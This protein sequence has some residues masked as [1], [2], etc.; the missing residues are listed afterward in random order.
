MTVH[1]AGTRT[2]PTTEAAL[3][4]Q[5]AI[6]RA[7]VALQTRVTRLRT[8]SRLLFLVL[9]FCVSAWTQLGIPAPAPAA[10][11]PEAPQDALG[12]STPRGA[13]LG[14]LGASHKGDNELAAEYLNTRLRGKAATDLAHQFFVVLDRRLPAQLNQLSDKPEGSLSDQLK[15]DQELVGTII[16]NDRKLDIFIERV[17]RGKSGSLWLFSSKTLD[18]IPDLYEEINAL[19]VDNVLPEFLVNTRFA[20]IRLFQWVAVFV[21]MPLFY[22]LTTLLNRVLSRLIG[23]F[24]RRLYKKPGLS[25][26]EVLPRP[27]RILLLAAVIRWLLTQLSLPLLARQF[28]SGVAVV[29]TIAGCVW[30]MILLNSWGEEYIRKRLQGSNLTGA[31]SILRLARWAIDGLIV[32]AGMLVT[33][34]YFG[35]KPT[36]ALAGLGVGGIAVALAAQKTLENVIGG[37]SLILDRAVRVG[38]TLKMGETVGTIDAIGLRSTRIRTL[39]RTVVSVPNGQISNLSLENLSARDKFW[40]HPILNL[41]VGTTSSKMHAV[42]ESIRSLLQESRHVE[43]DS[44]RVRFLRFGPSS[45]D[46]EVFAYV[47]ASDW[48]QFLEIQ[49]TLLLRIMECIESAG[50][51]VALP[52]QIIFMSAASA[53]PEAGVEGLLKA[54]APEKKISD[55]AATKSA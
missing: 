51:Q 25:N 28:W 29:I 10:T 50:V 2:V 1:L 27:V 26:P 18:S 52:S 35:V 21:G 34:Y 54:P 36:A 24:R 13:V 6:R 48:N 5:R 3:I 8:G 4:H 46:V 55:Q 47:L 44:I 17:D 20:G 49:E 22:F 15:P 23:Q 16:G 14:F 31:T 12:R 30:L 19:P 43:P 39:D 9:L 33:L 11:Q 53:S 42:L 40:L 38:D 37:V 32:F 41:R 45:L 7:S